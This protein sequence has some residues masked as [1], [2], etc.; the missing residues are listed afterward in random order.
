MQKLDV[1]DIEGTTILYSRLIEL[2]GSSDEAE[3]ILK[4]ELIDPLDVQYI[5]ELTSLLQSY[6]CN[7]YNSKS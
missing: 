2:C 3:K 1:L 4:K 5:N 7:E 6:S